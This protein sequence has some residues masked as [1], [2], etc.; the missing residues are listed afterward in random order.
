[1]ST[2]NFKLSFKQLTNVR[3]SQHF[4]FLMHITTN[5]HLKKIIHYI[6]IIYYITHYYIYKRKHV[7][8]LLI[9]LFFSL[10]LFIYLF[11]DPLY[12][13]YIKDNHY[14]YKFFRD[15]VRYLKNPIL[16]HETHVCKVICKE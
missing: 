12:I 9:F 5:L 6:L 16:N 13:F 3:K 7:H 11:I 1:M 2:L 4:S 10:Y 14:K 8:L 15:L